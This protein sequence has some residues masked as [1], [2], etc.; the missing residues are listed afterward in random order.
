M[1]N[2]TRPFIYFKQDECGAFSK[3]PTKAHYADAGWDLYTPVTVEIKAHDSKAIDTHT[4]V[5][6]PEGYVGFL[7]SKSGL[8]VKHSI[9]SEGVIDSGYTGTIVVKLY[10]RSNV[11]YK[12]NAGDKITQLVVLPCLLDSEEVN[13]EEWN[14]LIAESERGENGFGSSGR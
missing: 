5:H 11:D 13:D 7:K 9:V 10:N 3:A 4:R 14:K 12:F 8:N 2:N 6:I 1:E